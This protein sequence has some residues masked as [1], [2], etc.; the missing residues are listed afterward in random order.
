MD[1]FVGIGE[2]TKSDGADGTRTGWV[3]QCT[4]QGV[5]TSGPCSSVKTPFS[6][7]LV[8]PFMSK[9][10]TEVWNSQPQR[11]LL[12]DYSRPL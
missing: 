2:R 10:H 12:R 3:P 11:T 7:L 5:V 8:N 1:S 4:E 6:V 9:V